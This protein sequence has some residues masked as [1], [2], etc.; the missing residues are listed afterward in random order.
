MADN[1]DRVPI[2]HAKPEKI[3]RQQSQPTFR[4]GLRENIP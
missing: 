2:L 4:I 1:L 3:N